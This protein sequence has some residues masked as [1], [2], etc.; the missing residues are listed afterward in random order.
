MANAARVGQ[1]ALTRL[2][3][4]AGNHEMIADVRGRGLIFG[5]EF[6]TDR[7]TLNPP[8]VLCTALSTKCASAVCFCQ[9]SDATKTCSK[10]ARQ[11]RFQMTMS[12]C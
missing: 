8:P 1:Y 2:T 6:V 11:C 3:E 7:A 10:S 9:A 5:A 4:L 12:I